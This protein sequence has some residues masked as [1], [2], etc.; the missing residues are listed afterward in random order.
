[1]ASSTRQS[2]SAPLRIRRSARSCG[3]AMLDE[4][5][6]PSPGAVGP[7]YARCMATVHIRNDEVVVHLTRFEKVGAF[8]GDV[9]VPVR[10]VRSVDVTSDPLAVVTGVRAPGTAIP[11]RLKLGTWRRR[12]GKRDFVAVFRGRHAVVVELDSAECRYERL[13]VSVDEPEQIRREL[14]STMPS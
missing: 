6:D 7:P 9:R 11:G 10:A 4:A 2:W 1:M 12:G 8:H 14:A 13:I 5:Y 3:E